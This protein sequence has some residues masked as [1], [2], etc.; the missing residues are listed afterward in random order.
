MVGLT[1]KLP[2]DILDGL[3]RGDV[4]L[5]EWIYDCQ[6]IHTKKQRYYSPDLTPLCDLTADQSV[7]FLVTHNGQLHLF[8]NDEHCCEVTT[9]LP[10][11]TPLWGMA[12]VHARCTKIKSE[13]LI[14]K[15]SDVVC[16]GE[17]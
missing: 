10:T 5:H 11:D 7:G 4:G 1:S 6:T 15:L 14:G 3:H 12:E 17:E 16:G 2:S 8:L 13:I 9:G